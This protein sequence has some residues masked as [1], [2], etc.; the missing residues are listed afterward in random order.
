MPSNCADTDD[1]DSCAGKGVWKNDPDGY[2]EPV[3]DAEGQALRD[4]GR[5]GQHGDERQGTQQPHVS[6]APAPAR[7]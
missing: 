7:G 1:S 4:A 5:A 3:V 2:G 6:P